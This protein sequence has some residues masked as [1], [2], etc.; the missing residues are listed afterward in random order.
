MDASATV[1][2]IRKACPQLPKLAIV[3]GSGF[4]GVA[5]SVKISV[6]I[7][8]AKLPGFSRPTTAGH[9]GQ[10][11]MGTLGNVPVLFLNGR[12]HFYEGC[13]L[14]EVTFPVRVLSALGIS[15]LLLTNAAGAINPRFSLGQFMLVTDH[16]NMLPENPLRGIAG[17]AKFLDL[18]Q[19]YDPTL[20]KLLRRAARSAGVPLTPGVYLAVSGPTYETP[21]EIDAFAKLGADA[22]GMSTVPEAIVAR[23]CGMR[24]A[25][26]SCL[27][28]FAAGRGKGLLSHAEVLITGEKAKAAAAKLL[29]AFVTEYADSQ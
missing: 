2:R 11:I 26:V 14:A 5:S 28:N 18:S 29:K 12:R 21:A 17:T 15:D 1:A 8:Y 25:A 22:I 13:S 16:I 24:V 23:Y 3:L 20:G 4:A 6:E 27:T 9:P 7:A 19:A 10:L